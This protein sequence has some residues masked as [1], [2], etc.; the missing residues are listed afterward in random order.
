MRH[1]ILDDRALRE[2]SIIDAFDAALSF[3]KAVIR[4]TDGSY[5]LIDLVTAM[6]REGRSGL[7]LDSSLWDEWLKAVQSVCDQAE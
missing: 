1:P 3:I 2:I 5:D 7:P 4:N 6:N